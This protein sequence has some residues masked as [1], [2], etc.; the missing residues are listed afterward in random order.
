V[1]FR[2]P[3][4]PGGELPTEVQAIPLSGDYVHQPNVNNL[5]GI[6]ATPDGSTLI[7]IQSA[8]G[9][10]FSIDPG[11]GLTSR[12]DLG[13]ETLSTGDGLLLDG[14][15]LYVVRNRENRIAV[16]ELSPDL[17][18]GQI[19]GHITHPMFDV[20]TTIAEHGRALYAV[21]ARFGVP[22]PDGHYEAVRVPKD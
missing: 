19:A 11:S 18:S 21:N 13:G 16:I 8:T 2:L 3:F 17:S 15:T 22:D 20:P 5:N 10:L 12:I 6:E 1:L 9:T 4:G 14:K 7:A